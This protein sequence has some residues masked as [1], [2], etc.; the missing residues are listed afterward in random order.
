MLK[1]NMRQGGLS[2]RNFLKLF[3]LG[4]TSLGINPKF[5]FK[6]LT[7]FPDYERLGRVC[8]IGKVE[9]KSEPFEG[10]NT[11]GVLYEDAVFPWLRDVVAKEPN[12][13][14]YNQ[15]WLEMPD[16]YIYAVNVQPVRNI[17][18]QPIKTLLNTSMG[19]GMWAQVTIPYAD[20]TL[21]T[22]PSSNSWVKARIDQGLPLRVYYGQVYFIDQIKKDDDESVYYRVNPNYYGGVDMF[23]VPAEAMHPISLNEIEP[24]NPQVE[25]KRIVVDVA[26]QTLS[27]FEGESEVYYC[28]VSTGAKFD[29]YG[30]PV[31]KWSTPLG[32][33]QI[34][35]KFISLQMSGGTTGA[36]Y[37][38][39]G[40][41]WVSVFATGGVAIHATVWHNDFGTPKSH[42]C[43]NTLPEDANWIFRWSLPQIKYNPGMVDISVSGEPSTIIQ[44]IES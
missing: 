40:I 36:P 25:N 5:R 26:R 32:S 27:C 39:P 11:V 21:V 35:R 6:D 3:G 2:R 44:V 42:G 38:L 12:Y 1:R 31:E 13:N 24:I 19:D 7:K 29:M 15:R 16:G 30:N 34:S 8:I 4:L 9:I 22:S 18:N 17:P 23:W 14:F 20:V 41:G 28:R 43:I 10:S 37:D 33:Y